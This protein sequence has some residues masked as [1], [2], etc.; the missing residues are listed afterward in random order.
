[1][2]IGCDEAVQMAQQLMNV[3]DAL[4]KGRDILFNLCRE[5]SPAVINNRD[6]LDYIYTHDKELMRAYDQIAMSLDRAALIRH[7]KDN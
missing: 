6:D 5:R 7:M 3:S 2:T 4:R 1:M